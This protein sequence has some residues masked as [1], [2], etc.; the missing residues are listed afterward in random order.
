[1]SEDKREGQL[2]HNN[3][4]TAPLPTAASCLCWQQTVKL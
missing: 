3:N 4:A 2:L 1:M